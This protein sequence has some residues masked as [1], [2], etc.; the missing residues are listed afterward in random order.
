MLTTA[1]ERNHIGDVDSQGH[2]TDG[3]FAI[4]HRSGK[5]LAAAAKFL[6]VSG[7]FSMPNHGTR[8][9]AAADLTGM[10]NSGVVFA[11]SVPSTLWLRA[12][13]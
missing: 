1:S 10:L 5:V 11:R 3:G 7:G 4:S 8:H 12:S 9:T 13:G 6:C 2:P